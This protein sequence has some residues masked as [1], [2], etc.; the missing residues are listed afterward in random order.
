MSHTRNE[1]RNGMVVAA[2]KLT[3]EAGV[4]IL[5]AGGNAVDAAIGA[6]I[7]N[8]VVKPDMNGLGGSRGSA[9]L[10]L[11]SDNR[12]VAIDF[13]AAAPRD[14]RDDL[15]KPIRDEM[16]SRD[17]RQRTKQGGILLSGYAAVDDANLTGPLAV[18]TPP[19]LAGWKLALEVGGTMDLQDLLQACIPYAA[20]GFALDVD[21]AHSIQA[22]FERIQA[23]PETA[24]ILTPRGRPP[25]AGERLVQSDLA[26][27][28]QRLIEDGSEDFYQGELAQRIVDHVQSRGG[29]LAKDDME[30][31]R[32]RLESNPLSVSYRG[33]DVF[34]PG[35]ASSGGITVLQML[36]IL[37]H[38]PIRSLSP[39]GAEFI[40]VVAE[41]MKL[42][43]QD[44]LAHMGD[45]ADMKVGPSYFLSESRAE[46]YARRVQSQANRSA[47]PRNHTLPSGFG[48]TTHICVVDKER[49]VVS[50]TQTLGWAFGSLMTVPETGIILGNALMG[51]FDPKPGQANSVGPRKRP[52]QRA[53]PVIAFSDG[54]PVMAVGGAG[55]RRIPNVVLQV[56]ID[57]L[58]YHLPCERIVSA[59]RFHI[60]A[61]EPL[62]LEHG[63][64]IE[65]GYSD[66]TARELARLGH[67]LVSVADGPEIRWPRVARVFGIVCDLARG[68]LH[69]GVQGRPLTRELAKGY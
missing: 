32:A 6:A 26:Q 47:A 7:V 64:A 12:T 37:E 43:W 18:A 13:S 44:R 21:T 48:N 19:L 69:G 1:C 27:T 68:T 22:E 14:A 61:D 55:G 8:C 34:S 52:V 5:Q 20:E 3:A 11:A 4:R 2:H 36:K 56:L 31:Y 38:L 66:E 35:M 15:Y 41:A 67:R 28:I 50:L 51:S 16:V 54:V 33:F 10:H 42:A 49:N 25:G 45:P 62:L 63:S 9:L 59:P 46:S 24:R 57:L 30:E 29:I 17:S 60:E 58:D 23:F 65:W 39:N 40:H 53:C